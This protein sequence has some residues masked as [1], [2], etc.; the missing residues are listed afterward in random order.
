MGAHPNNS[1]NLLVILAGPLSK[2]PMPIPSCPES[3]IPKE[4]VKT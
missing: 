3:M 4:I 2:V 1:L